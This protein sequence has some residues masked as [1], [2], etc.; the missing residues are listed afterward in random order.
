LKIRPQTFVCLDALFNKNDEL[1][2][3]TKLQFKDEGIEFRSI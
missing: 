2:T 3:N 1:K